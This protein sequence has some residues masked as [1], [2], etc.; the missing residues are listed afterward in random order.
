MQ[1]RLQPTL[2]FTLIEITHG[3]GRV[4]SAS[5]SETKV[6]SSTPTG[7]IIYDAY[8]SVNC[9]TL[10]KTFRYFWSRRVR[11]DLSESSSVSQD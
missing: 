9:K 11:R 7:A 3:G 10:L 6:I 8:T 2:K 5:G 4:V 1:D